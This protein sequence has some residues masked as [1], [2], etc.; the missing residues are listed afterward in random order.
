MIIWECCKWEMAIGVNLE[1]LLGN[2]QEWKEASKI[3]I[4]IPF[5][6]NYGTPR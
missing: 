4:K 3:N 6:T 5:M 1:E 2:I